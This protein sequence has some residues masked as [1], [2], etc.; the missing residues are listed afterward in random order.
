AAAASL[1]RHSLEETG[2]AVVAAYGQ[3]ASA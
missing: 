1:A 2:R 3:A